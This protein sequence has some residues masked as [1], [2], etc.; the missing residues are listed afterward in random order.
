ML[1]SGVL[2]L[3]SFKTKSG[4]MSPYF[5]DAGRY[6]RGAQLARDGEAHP[7]ESHHDKQDERRAGRAHRDAGR[8]ARA[9]IERDARREVV[10]GERDSYPQQD[11]DAEARRHLNF[12]SLQDGTL[13]GR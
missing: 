5:L 8:H 2:K 3:G 4:R 9:V 10:R 6:G 11:R 12:F 1:E 7:L 13:C